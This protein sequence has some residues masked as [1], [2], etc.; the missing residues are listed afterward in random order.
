M[1]ELALHILDICNNSVDAGASWIEITIDEATKPDHIIIAIG[2]NGKGMDS[3]M[4]SRVEDPWFT[5]RTTRKQGLGIPLIKQQ[6]I[7]SGGSF[8]I[9][10]EPGEG[11][12]VLASFLKES[13]DR[14]PM[15]DLAGV[16]L[17]LSGTSKEIRVVMNYLTETGSWRFDTDE[18]KSVLET[19]Q[20]TGNGLTVALREMIEYN[21]G[22]LNP[23]A[24]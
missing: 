3:E 19:E 7:T 24:Y 6:A 21:V 10:S 16:L 18:I 8:R 22:E 2:D 1:K 15:G 12:T 23:E 20:I 4:S 17:I 11:T 13:V 14:Q 5:T 9:E